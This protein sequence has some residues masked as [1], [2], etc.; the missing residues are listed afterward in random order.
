LKK[1]DMTE[2]IGAKLGVVVMTELLG[3][4]SWQSC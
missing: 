1:E 4:A 2:H 3:N